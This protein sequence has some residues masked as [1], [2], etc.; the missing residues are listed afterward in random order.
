MAFYCWEL[1]TGKTRYSK[2]HFIVELS[3][4]INDNIEEPHD[5]WMSE[6]TSTE[7]WNSNFAAMSKDP[8][9]IGFDAHIWEVLHSAVPQWDSVNEEQSLV[10]WV[11]LEVGLSSQCSHYTSEKVS[12][13]FFNL[14]N[15]VDCAWIKWNLTQYAACLYTLFQTPAHSN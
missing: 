10:S 15:C 2:T 6:G 1:I 5:T 3:Q 8:K 7:T 11:F 14:V 4:L 12:L 13:S 9:L